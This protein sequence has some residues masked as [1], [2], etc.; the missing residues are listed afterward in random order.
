MENDFPK[1]VV[2][3]VVVV[4][5][6]AAASVS[7]FHFCL[8][9]GRGLSSSVDEVMRYFMTTCT[10]STFPDEFSSSSV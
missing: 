4:G 6:G 3:L 2:T 1:R 8:N 5:G 9:I 7:C 10:G